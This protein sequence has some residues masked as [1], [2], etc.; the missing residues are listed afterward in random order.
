ML[1]HQKDKKFPPIHTDVPSFALLK[2]KLQN[3]P[4]YAVLFTLETCV[5]EPT[6]KWLI[7]TPNG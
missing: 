7:N 5:S 4:F 3:I 6:T 2:N 1:V